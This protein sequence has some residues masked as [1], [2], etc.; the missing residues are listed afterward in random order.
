[1]RTVS[2]FSALFLAFAS[3][4]CAAT[5]TAMWRY[6]VVMPEK[7]KFNTI[8]KAEQI[9]LIKELEAIYLDHETN[10]PSVGYRV[11][12][13]SHTKKPCELYLQAYSMRPTNKAIPIPP[14]ND[15]CPF[16][17]KVEKRDEKNGDDKDLPE[18]III[19]TESG[20]SIAITKDHH[21]QF[22]DLTTAEKLALINRAIKA[23][24]AQ[25]EAGS[26]LV[27]QTNIGQGN[28]MGHQSIPHTHMHIKH[29]LSVDK[30]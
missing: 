7:T 14:L 10:Y 22:F 19:R 12:L 26:G 27:L 24:E 20:A 25:E 13:E 8:P 1:M 18:A 21:E 4:A 30:D 5:P 11:F 23:F 28:A 17:D 6:D 2:K 15:S 9:R 16:C 29:S 3:L